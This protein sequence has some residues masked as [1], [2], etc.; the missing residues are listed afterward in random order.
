MAGLVTA[1]MGQCS[2]KA[3]VENPKGSVEKL[4]LKESVKGGDTALRGSVRAPVGFSK[5]IPKAANL[6]GRRPQGF[7]A[8]GF[9][10][11]N[12]E[13]ARGTVMRGQF[14]HSA[15]RTFNSCSDYQIHEV[16]W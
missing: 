16:Y 5:G 12:P 9:P 10:K 8:E 6:R 1:S 14:F 2:V 4:S 15:L 13:G 3:T 11:E 7:A